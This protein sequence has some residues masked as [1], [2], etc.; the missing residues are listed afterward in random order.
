MYEL[1]VSIV[2]L[3][4]NNLREVCE[5]RAKT[6][7]ARETRKKKEHARDYMKIDYTR[8]AIRLFFCTIKF[9]P[10]SHEKI[11]LSHAK[12]LLLQLATDDSREV[13]ETCSQHKKM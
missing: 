7:K 9:Y 13:C 11:P 3:A 6:C 2:K 12:L 4:T 10:L 1:H 5:M 8:F